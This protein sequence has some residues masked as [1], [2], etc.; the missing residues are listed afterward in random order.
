MTLDLYHRAFGASLP[1]HFSY[2]IS[3]LLLL[4]LPSTTCGTPSN[5]DTSY[6]LPVT[7]LLI[8]HA[9]FLLPTTTKQ[10]P[11]LTNLLNP[12]ISAFYVLAIAYAH[13]IYFDRANM[14]CYEY[15]PLQSMWLK[16][17]IITFYALVI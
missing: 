1:L 17:E 5:H 7:L 9:L 10:I 16:I 6:Q 14:Y 4:S 8:S 13:H 15:V 3:T 11:H 12:V 2:L